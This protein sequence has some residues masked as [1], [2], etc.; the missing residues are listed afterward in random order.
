VRNTLL[1]VGSAVYTNSTAT[2]APGFANN[3]NFNSANLQITTG[4]NR[5]D[6]SATVLDP[7]FPNAPNGDFTVKNQT[8]IDRKVGDPRWLK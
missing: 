3:N 5:P 8:L 1:A 6:A 4:N 7:Q 2:A